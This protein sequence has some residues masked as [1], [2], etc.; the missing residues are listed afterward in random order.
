VKTI[1]AVYEVCND[2]SKTT[3]LK[4]LLPETF[5]QKLLDEVVENC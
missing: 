3:N 2:D 5:V 4:L 1:E